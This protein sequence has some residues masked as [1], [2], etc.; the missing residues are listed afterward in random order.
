MVATGLRAC[1]ARRYA[2][3]PG[4]RER[5]RLHRPDELNG[6]RG[7]QGE[8]ENACRRIYPAETEGNQNYFFSP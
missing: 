7:L 8:P 5:L 6:L 1:E 4:T 2:R 3:Q